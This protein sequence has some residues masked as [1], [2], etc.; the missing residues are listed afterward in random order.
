MESVKSFERENRYVVIKLSKCTKAQIER[1]DAT[2]DNFASACVDCVVVEH[3]WPEYEIVWAMI[4][5]RMGGKPVPDFDR[6]TA[7]N[8]ALQQRLTVQD[9]RV[10]ELEA[11]V[12]RLNRVKF[13][14]KE[15]AESHAGNLSVSRYHLSEAL[16]MSEKVRDASLGMRSKRLNDL[17]VYLY[18]NSDAA[19]N[20]TAEAEPQCLLCLDKKT[21]PGNIPVGFVKDCPDCC[22]EEG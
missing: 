8:L 14:L 10:D 4:E 13:A 22:G 12:A 3:H 6:V 18:Q 21:V 9:Q 1:L 15:L 5:H 7:E 11:E 16:T 19:L 2:F 17:I 20:P